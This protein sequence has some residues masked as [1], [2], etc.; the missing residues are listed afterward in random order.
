MRELFVEYGPCLV[1][2]D[3]WRSDL[4][5]RESFSAHKYSLQRE[6]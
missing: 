6:H 5:S 4:G 3:E 2:I 1:L